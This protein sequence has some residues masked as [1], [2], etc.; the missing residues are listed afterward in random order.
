MKACV[1]PCYI[2]I[3]FV[4]I[5]EVWKE[6]IEFKEEKPVLLYEVPVK[7]RSKRGSIY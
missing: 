7:N 4:S 1:F 6:E 3:V 2:K 5:S